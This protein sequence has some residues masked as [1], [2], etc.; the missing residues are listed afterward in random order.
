MPGNFYARTMLEITCISGELYLAVPLAIGMY[1]QTAK[2]KS[3]ILEEEF[4]EL[5]NPRGERIH[6]FVFNKGL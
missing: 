3:S 1:P 5:T 4:R 6:T 2:I